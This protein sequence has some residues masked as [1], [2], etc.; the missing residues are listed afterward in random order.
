MK[1]THLFLL[2]LAVELWIFVDLYLLEEVQVAVT[3]SMNVWLD[4]LAVKNRARFVD[5]VKLIYDN[6]YA[7]NETNSLQKIVVKI[8]A[9][10]L[11]DRG[12]TSDSTVLK[13]V[14]QEHPSLGSQICI[15]MEVRNGKRNRSE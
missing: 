7:S 15:E 10:D 14:L 6:I 13:G 5:I 3:K 8:L 12:P 9:A 1:V 2:Y 4:W 11:Q